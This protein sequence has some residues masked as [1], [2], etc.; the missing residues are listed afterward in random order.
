MATFVLVHGAWHGG[1]CYA[2]V[3][4]K[5]RAAGHDVF[6]PTH[7]GVGERSHLAG[8][9]EVNLSLHVKDVCQVIE[10]ENLKD[11]ILCG[12]SYGGMV[13]S[14]VAAALGDRIKSLV[15]L[16]AFVPEDGQ[17]LFDFLPAELVA[18]FVAGAKAGGG[19]LPPI[20]AEA[21]NVNPADAAWVNATCVP[22]AFATFGEPVKFTGKEKKVKNRT[23]ILATGYDM[24][25]FDQ[26]HTKLKNDAAWKVT[27]V[28]CGHDVML[29]KPDEL[30]KL[31]LEEVN[32]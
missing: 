3:A 2:R 26:F 29:D 28:P 14:G 30:A 22:Q 13:I 15:F 1:W 19:R 10:Y 24:H 27:T 8:S 16:D 32:R 17:C 9:A 18:Q 6:T 25:V 5:L 7:T 21:F 20:P 11:V 23:Y 12:H 4:K 31:L